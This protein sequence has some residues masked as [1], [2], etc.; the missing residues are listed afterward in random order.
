MTSYACMEA[1]F[2]FFEQKYVEFTKTEIQKQEEKDD[3][4]EAKKLRTDL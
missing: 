1:L 3:S 4:I 2:K